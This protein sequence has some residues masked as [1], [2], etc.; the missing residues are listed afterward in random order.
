M[1]FIDNYAI[2]ERLKNVG[3]QFVEG[4]SENEIEN[5]ETIFGFRFPKE[6]ADFFAFAYPQGQGFFN[7]KDTSPENVK[8][9]LKFQEKIKEM[10]VFDVENNTESLRAMLKDYLGVFSSTEEFKA[11]VLEAL[12]KSPKLIP[13][14]F[15]RCFFD[16]MDGLPIVSFW[17]AVDTIFY[18]SDLENYFEN[19]FINPEEFDV[20][21][22]SD[23]FVNTGI[24]RHIAGY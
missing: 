15:H 23:E 9:F 6:I 16:G 3:V 24:W 18:G 19:E 7:Y 14:Y 2:V 5:I 21:D 17:Q 13:F 11:A 8:H 20:G 1:D 10:F 12:E 22:V 4:L